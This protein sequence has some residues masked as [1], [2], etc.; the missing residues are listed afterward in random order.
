M[1]RRRLRSFSTSTSH[2]GGPGE[3]HIPHPYTHSDPGPLGMRGRDGASEWRT[4]AWGTQ[5]ES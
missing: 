5:W 3:T 2:P 1:R 4:R